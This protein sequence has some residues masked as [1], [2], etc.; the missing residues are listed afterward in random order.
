M[1][2]SSSFRVITV[3][4]VFRLLTDFVC[5][6]NY[7]FLL[8]FCKIVRSSVILLLPLLDKIFGQV[9]EVE[10]GNTTVQKRADQ[11]RFHM[12]SVVVRFCILVSIFIKCHLLY[13]LILC[14]IYEK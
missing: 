13:F 9:N 3:F 14:K 4:T 8:S 5:L 10:T 1:N 7:D 2:G 6:Y 12:F 11:K